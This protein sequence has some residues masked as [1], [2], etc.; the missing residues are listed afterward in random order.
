[1]FQATCHLLGTLFALA[2]LVFLPFSNEGLPFSTHAWLLPLSTAAFVFLSAARL[3]T[4][5]RLNRNEIP[6]LALA[7]TLTGYGWLLALFPSGMADRETGTLLALDFKP[8]LAFGSVDQESSVCAMKGVT[9]TAL[10][11]VCA[12]LLA[13]RRSGRVAIAAA[14]TVAG[15]VAALAGLWLQTSADRSG[16]WQSPHVP[17]SVFGLF[18]YHGSAGAFLNLAWPCAAWLFLVVRQSRLASVLKNS[19]L[20]LLAAAVALQLIAVAANVSKMGHVVALFQIV[21]LMG[22]LYALTGHRQRPGQPEFFR[23]F[24]LT[25]MALVLVVVAAWVAGA[26]QGWVRWGQFSQRGFDDPARRHATTMAIRMGQDAGWMGTGPG[27]FAVVS[28]HYSVLDPLLV[29]GHWRYAH[30]DYMQFFAEWGALGALL[31]G[32]LLARPLFQFSKL[33]TIAIWGRSHEQISFHRLTAL[34]CILPACASTLIHATV[35]FPLQIQ[36][37]QGLFAV[38]AAMVLSLTSYSQD[39][40]GRQYAGTRK[41]SQESRLAPLKVI[42]HSFFDEVPGERKKP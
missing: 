34:G 26:S 8:W 28:P 24:L 23:S 11:F 12:S 19:L 32:G 6:L 10:M 4:K 21:L 14:V 2:V 15:M 29:G 39:K 20:G 25:G 13:A 38:L 9:T 37:T 33:A 22:G 27:T 1:M 35:D 41:S 16:L 18:W 3:V 42:D 30:N 17:A 31:L 40:T 36:A 5:S 7:I